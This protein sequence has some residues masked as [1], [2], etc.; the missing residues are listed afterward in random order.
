[1]NIKNLISYVF[2]L[3]VS[4]G[5]T[6]Y[7]NG[8]GGLMLCI[9]LVTAFLLSLV[10]FLAVK[11]KIIFDIK[12]DNVNLRKDDVFCVL[13]S[14]SKKCMLP[15]PYVEI[16]LRSSQKLTPL[17]SE[18][19]KTS[20]FSKDDVVKIKAEYKADFSGKSTVGIEYVKVTDF[21]GLFTKYIYTTSNDDIAEL[22]V[23]PEIPDSVFSTEMIKAVADSVS[24]NDDDDDS[25]DTIRYGVG[26][27]G[28]E[29]RDYVPGDPIRKINWKLSSKRDKHLIRLDE[30]NS[31]TGQ[32]VVFDIFTNK[33]DRQTYFD[34]DNLIEGSL[35]L[36]LSMIRQELECECYVYNKNGWNYYKVNDEKSLSFLQTELGNYDVSQE[37]ISRFPNGI[38]KEKGT[39]AAV[40]FTNNLD[41]NVVKAGNTPTVQSFYVTK[42]SFVNYKT[43][44]IWLID[45]LFELTRYR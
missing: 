12:Y 1:L 45:Q 40:V 16:K 20:L 28:Y 2:C 14:V 22:R 9:C 37:H 38:E 23:L 8:K 18:I 39:A 15:T 4:I 3:V 31:V 13:L 42:E 17:K 34:V 41:H 25:G 30:K 26:T 7:I 36:I 43:D 27:P 44:N 5:L 33:T 19:F 29:H 6:Y 35:G 10:N 32:L 24:Y 11:D 21:L